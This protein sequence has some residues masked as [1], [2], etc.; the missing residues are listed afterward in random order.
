[1]LACSKVG[2]LYKV[3]VVNHGIEF[4]SICLNVVS[5]IAKPL[6]K[7]RVLLCKDILCVCAVGKAAIIKGSLVCSHWTLIQ[8]I[9]TL[10]FTLIRIKWFRFRIGNHF[11]GFTRC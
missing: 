10:N 9:K 4:V 7:S 5:N 2:Y 11:N 6:H 8:K 3:G 1:M